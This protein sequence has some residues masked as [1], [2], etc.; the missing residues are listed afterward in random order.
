M[1]L[2]ECLMP[3]D[4]CRA[5]APRAVWGGSQHP[6]WLGHSG[7]R[8]DF[9][10]LQCSSELLLT[11]M[12]CMLGGLQVLLLLR[13]HLAGEA[14]CACCPLSAFNGRSS[15][16]LEAKWSWDGQ[17]S[18]QTYHSGMRLLAGLC[19]QFSFSRWL[20][21]HQ[22]RAKATGRSTPSASSGR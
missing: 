21:L 4:A 19:W 12:L 3:D 8:P 1:A 15:S 7:E 13:Q 9:L 20:A 16:M 2:M 10:Q 5:P 18:P 11:C 22:H 6:P 17:P 14:A